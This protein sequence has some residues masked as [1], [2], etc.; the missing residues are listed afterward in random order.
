MRHTSSIIIAV[1]FVLSAS[2]A[3]S[4]RTRPVAKAKASSDTDTRLVNARVVEVTE[5]RISVIAQTGVEHVIAV[6]RKDTRVTVRGQEVSLADLR[7]GDI[8]T[9]TLDPSNPMLFAKNIAMRA[10][11]MEVA[12][13]R[14]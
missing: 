2:I 1:V 3:G 6:D 9:V 14:R 13:V 4:A 12:R 10:G 11:P 5:S 7:E 8:I